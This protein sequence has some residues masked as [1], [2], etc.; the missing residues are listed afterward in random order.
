M[1]PP[2]IAATA[3][4][5]L[6]VMICLEL[7]V[8]QHRKKPPKRASHRHARRQPLLE[9]RLRDVLNEPQEQYGHIFTSFTIWKRDQDTRMELFTGPP[10]LQLN[11]FTRLLVVRHIWRALEK[12]ARGSVVVIDYPPLEFTAQSDK[13]FDDHGIDPWGGGEEKPE[14]DGSQFVKDR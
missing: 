13:E 3:L 10:W 12:L 14:A 8:I 7:A 6:M 11:E 1:T 5:V 2:L 4:V 9:D